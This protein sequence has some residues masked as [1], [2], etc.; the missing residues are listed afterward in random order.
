MLKR[1]HQTTMSLSAR[2]DDELLKLISSEPKGHEQAFSELYRRYD[3]RIYAY[4]LRIMGDKDQAKDIFQDTFIR[5][6]NQAQSGKEITTVIGMLIRIARNLC[7]NAKRDA[8]PHIILDELTELGIEMP[9]HDGEL[10]NLINTS[11]EL[12]EPSY[13]EAIVLR[14]Y[15][16]LSYEEM[17]RITGD[18]ISTLKNRVWRGKEKLRNLLTPYMEEAK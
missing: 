10:I 12:L 15:Q 6:Y 11:L 13:R 9:E 14:L 8:K 7:L 4:I 18:T 2:N 16:D 3:R 1:L 5:F 17:S